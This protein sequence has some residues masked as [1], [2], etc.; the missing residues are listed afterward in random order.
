M[1]EMG[2]HLPPKSS[3]PSLPERVKTERLIMG[4]IIEYSKFGHLRWRLNGEAS[5]GVD[6]RRG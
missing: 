3:P 6:T 4:T 1:P 5:R 2:E